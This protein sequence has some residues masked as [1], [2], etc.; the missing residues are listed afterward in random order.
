MYKNNGLQILPPLT[1]IFTAKQAFLSPPC[2]CWLDYLLGRNDFFDANQ[3]ALALF[4]PATLILP[5]RRLSSGL[6]ST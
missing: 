4:V 3:I 2:S 1:N 6:E 5:K